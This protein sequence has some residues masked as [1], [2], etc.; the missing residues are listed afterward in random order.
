MEEC[1]VCNDQVLSCACDYNE[2]PGE[3]LPKEEPLYDSYNINGKELAKIPIGSET[4]IDGEALFQESC[5]GCKFRKGTSH[6]PGCTYEECPNCH[7]SIM[8]ECK[9]T[10]SD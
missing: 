10:F 3:N 8:K 5:P 6:S 4:Y 2:D 9:C 7:K 1:P